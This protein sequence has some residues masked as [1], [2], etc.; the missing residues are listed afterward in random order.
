ME[1]TLAGL[2]VVKI[3]ILKLLL[4]SL[5]HC[6]MAT[7]HVQD[8]GVSQALSPFSVSVISEDVCVY[9]GIRLFGGIPK[10]EAV[11]I[12]EVQAE[13]DR[14]LRR[15]VYSIL[16]GAGGVYG[17]AKLLEDTIVDRAANQAA[18]QAVDQISEMLQRNLLHRRIDEGLREE[19]L[20]RA[21]NS[22]KSPIVTKSHVLVPMLAMG[23]LVW[24]YLD[25]TGQ[26]RENNEVLEG[27][28][29]RFINKL[30]DE[31]LSRLRLKLEHFTRHS[32]P[33]R[34]N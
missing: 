28:I 11:K 6:G 32:C 19:A 31:Q 15:T 17:L 4:A 8:S 2:F 22:K 9:Y 14:D 3:L 1:L 24:Y 16:A 18:E 33:R 29:Q 21:R 13:K 5:S 20:E 23:A 12:F 27:D 7:D 10:Q 25:S 34:L 30:D 26:D